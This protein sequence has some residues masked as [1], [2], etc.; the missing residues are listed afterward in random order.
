[1]DA[2]A[3]RDAL[4]QVSGN[5]DLTAGG[6]AVK[7]TDEFKRRTVYG[8]V[9]RKKL[10]GTLALFDFA[11]P[12]NTSESRIVTNVPLQKLFFMNSSF[13]A[14][15]AKR[16]VDRLNSPGVSDDTARI[17]DAYRI[18][19][20]RLPSKNELKLGLD[21]VRERKSTWWEYTQALMSSNEFVYIN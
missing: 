12:N 14:L 10:D 13:V 1:L 5:L 4:L 15:Q 9:S 20:G 11:N 19:F 16:L 3:L 7:M 18:L 2:E 8:F 6:A 21:F 17:N